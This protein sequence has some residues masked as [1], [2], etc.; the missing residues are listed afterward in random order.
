MVVK[1]SKPEINVREKINELDKPSGI[2]G[3]AMLAAGT[4]QE[5]FNL[6]KAGRKNL[7]HNSQFMISQR[8]DFQTSATSI[9]V[10]NPTF[11]ADR[12]FTYGSGATTSA[13]ILNTT[14]PTGENVK[15]LKTIYTGS[16]AGSWV[17]PAQKIEPEYWMRGQPITLSA[18][19]RTNIADYRLRICD[20]INCYM[21]GDAIPADGNWHYMTAT[22]IL[23]DNMLL[24]EDSNANNIQIQP[25]FQTTGQTLVQNSSFVEFAL[26]QAEI[27]PVATPFEYRTYAEEW[28]ICQ[29]YYQRFNAD[30]QDFTNIGVAIATN[31]AWYVPI[32]L[33]GGRMRI[34]PSLSYSAVSDFRITLQ[35]SNSSAVTSMMIGY[36][37]PLHPNLSVQSGSNSAANGARMF[38]YGSSTTAW[39]A[40]SAEW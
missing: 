18:W 24:H 16:T 33:P 29:R 30:G 20:T 1:V 40:F 37:N 22:H 34:D 4:P 7:L 10:S 2:A 36:G 32:I 13:Q 28:Q 12:W 9:A 21:I 38:G 23:P 26:M 11:T 39:L 19:V 35:H 3:Q 8:G 31:S 5:Q 6:I 25:A 15:S 27:G 14:L 17:H